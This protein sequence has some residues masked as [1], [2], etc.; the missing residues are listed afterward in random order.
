MKTEDIKK[1]RYSF[2]E[3]YGAEKVLQLAIGKKESFYVCG[4]LLNS[5]S[6]LNG[7]PIE[8]QKGYLLRHCGILPN[9]MLVAEC[10]NASVYNEVG[11]CA[12][13]RVEPEGVCKLS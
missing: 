7:K 13:F 9:G 12:F 5:E 8:L 2:C 4:G 6:E 1:D 3:V 11:D 10:Y